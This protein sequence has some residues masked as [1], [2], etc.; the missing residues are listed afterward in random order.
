MT[1]EK[2]MEQARQTAMEARRDL[3]I[4]LFPT[5]QDDA[6]LHEWAQA[7]LGARIGLAHVKVQ[8]AHAHRISDRCWH[9]LLPEETACSFLGRRQL[10]HELAHCLLSKDALGIDPNNRAL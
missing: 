5:E 7:R 8:T 4:E 1:G 6:R 9:I 2:R 10:V 3:G